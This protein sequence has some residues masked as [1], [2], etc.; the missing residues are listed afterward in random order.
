MNEHNVET[1]G[2]C[3]IN[4]NDEY[5]LLPL[6]KHWMSIYPPEIADMST[7]PV[8][9]KQIYSAMQKIMEQTHNVDYPTRKV[10]E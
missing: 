2:Y 1:C 10:K 3:N 6:M 8:E 5:G 9:F 7:S 4:L